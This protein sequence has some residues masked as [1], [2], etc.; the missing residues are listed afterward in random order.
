VRNGDPLQPPTCQPLT[1]GHPWG[2]L[3]MRQPAGPIEIRGV[4]TTPKS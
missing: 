3:L 2:F 1:N 4:E